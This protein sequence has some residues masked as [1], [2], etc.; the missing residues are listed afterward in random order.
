MPNTATHK[1]E[2]PDAMS[3]VVKIG[4]QRRSWNIPH[5]PSNSGRALVEGPPAEIR[6]ESDRFRCLLLPN[7]GNHSRRFCFSVPA[8]RNE[9]GLCR[10]CL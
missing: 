3:V 4:K 2:K 8:H 6:D 9:P 10:W 7:Q 1:N 5:T